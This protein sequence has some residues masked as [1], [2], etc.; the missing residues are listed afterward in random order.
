M[1]QIGVI[2]SGG[3]S[4]SGVLTVNSISPNSS[5]NFT[6]NAG[7]N[8]TITSGTNSITISASG[9]GSSFVYNAVTS[10]QT[11][12]VNS[13]Y[14]V[15]ANAVTLTLPSIAAFGSVIQVLLSTGTSFTIAQ[16]VLQQIIYGKFTTTTGT[17]GS[18]TST[19]TG[20]AVELVCVVANTTWQVRNSE[21]NL[22]Y[23]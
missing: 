11:M 10:S 19:F 14:V 12:S 13:G 18:L 9:S 22:I 23:V 7:S 8:V 6:I 3:S 20:D 17:S 16:P 5:G 1:S 21:G 4:S 15:T 2:G